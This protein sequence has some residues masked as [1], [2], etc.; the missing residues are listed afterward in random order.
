MAVGSLAKKQ[1]YRH[2][3]DWGVDAREPIL[4]LSWERK[5]KGEREKRKEKENNSSNNSNNNNKTKQKQKLKRNYEGS[6]RF[7]G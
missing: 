7:C 3:L 2:L 5:G 4:S 1:H 6:T